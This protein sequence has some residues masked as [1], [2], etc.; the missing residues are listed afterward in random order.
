MDKR[1]PQT[2]HGTT[3]Q[4]EAYDRCADE[5]NTQ[6]A[7]LMACKD[8]STLIAHKIQLT[9]APNELQLGC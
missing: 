7:L 6:L 4:K 8:D 2:L 9:A 3:H 5:S 1:L